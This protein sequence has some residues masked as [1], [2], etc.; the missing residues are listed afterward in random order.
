MP[1]IKGISK[2]DVQQNTS[3]LISS[4]YTAK[5]AYAIAKDVQR[6]AK[7]KNPSGAGW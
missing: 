1:L 2:E 4:G 5:Q 7:L 6:K 3:E